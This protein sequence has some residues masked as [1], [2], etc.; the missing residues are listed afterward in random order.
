VL[1]ACATA[2]A[3]AAAAADVFPL[4]PL[5]R[6][7]RSVSPSTFLRRVPEI[8][9]IYLFYQLNE[10]NLPPPLR[11]RLGVPSTLALVRRGRE[12]F[13]RFPLLV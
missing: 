11:P 8:V 3:A 12:H 13:L 5:P 9:I 2:A 1:A 10:Y 7:L 6:R 4:F